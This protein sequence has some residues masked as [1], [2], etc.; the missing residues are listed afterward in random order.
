MAH[1]SPT[2][3]PTLWSQV[4]LAAQEPDSERGR[5]AVARLCEM[6]WYPVYAAFRRKGL[7]PADAEDMAQA[8]FA[9]VLS[10]GFFARADPKIGRFRNFLLGAIGHFFLNERD[11]ALAQRRGGHVEKISLDVDL[12]ENWLAAD[13]HPA[14]DAAAAF[15]RAWAAA[16]INH[17]LV[18][19]EAEQTA[20]GKG[21][22]FR[23]LKVFLQHNA[24]PG[25]YDEVAQDLGLSKGAV[26]AA[27][28]RLNLRFGELVRQLVRDT[29]VDPAMADNEMRCLFATLN[30]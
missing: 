11:R 20:A 19:L 1:G 27:V 13:T 22:A 15:D 14:S 8:F 7:G 29:V 2:F 30:G 18:K 4:L 3:E 26:A 25:E 23:R 10:N 28:H 12:A 9:H 24:R 17:A 5:R 16:L 21:P 6:Y